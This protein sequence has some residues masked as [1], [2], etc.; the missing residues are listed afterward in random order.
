MTDID[1]IL[2]RLNPKTAEAFRKASEL[3]TEF[4]STPSLGINMA[5]GGL[6]YGA[7][8][9]IWGNRSSGKT[10]FCLALAAQA[11]RDGKSVAWVD[12]EKNFDREW[13]VRNGVDPDNLIVSRTASMADTANNAVDLVRNGIDLLIVD[14]MSVLL[15]QSYF[16]DGEMKDLEK[17]NQIGTFAK[18]YGSMVNML[19]NLNQHTCIVMISQ[20]RNKF[21]Q[22]G[23]SK[24]LMGG[25]AAEFMNSTIIKLWSPSAEKEAI[26]GQIKK[27]DL[28][29]ERPIGRPVVGT[30]DKSRGPGMYQS[31]SYDLYF[32]GDKIGIDLVGEITDFGVEYG[33][34]NKGGAWYSYGEEK[35]QGR[36]KLIDYLNENHEVKELI[37][38]E[39]LERSA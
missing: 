28:I 21:H 4:L 35:F 25:E 27:G 1:T 17:T 30:I 2:A 18:N 33:V 22:Y 5:I 19:N 23:A 11:Q 39:L 37:Y 29:L 15:P 31:N 38:K 20:V 9:T 7:I 8:H 13:A 26:K 6:R 3:E 16:E 14:S 34:I 10:L 36:A 12:A 32:E 24:S